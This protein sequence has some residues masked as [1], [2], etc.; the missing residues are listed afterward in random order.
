M[1][2]SFDSAEQ[3]C[4][5]VNA[6]FLAGQTP[7]VCEF[8]EPLA[9]ELSS[10]LTGIPF[11]HDA[12]VKAYLLIEADG[13]DLLEVEKSIE[14]MYAVLD[15][16]GCIN[17]LMAD[18]EDKKNQFWRLR[19]SIGEATKKGN[20]YKEEDTVV[21]RA[22]LPALYHGVKEIAARYGLRTVCYGH[23]GDG[24]LHVNILKDQ[25]TDSYWNHEVKEA[26]REIFQLCYSLKGTISGEH[27]I[28]L[29]QKEYMPIVMPEWQ[30][31][32]M[33]GIKQVFD[34]RGILNPGKIF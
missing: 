34:P 32:L 29:V 27:G 23:A 8:V 20:V 6:L 4:R 15:T 16:N 33:R 28:G 22:S 26:I 3:V 13:F 2:A 9:F 14:A 19:R 24:N 30:L 5:A 31:D 17:V 1:L 10:N 12:A 11:Q 21:P 25:L 7:S 18:S